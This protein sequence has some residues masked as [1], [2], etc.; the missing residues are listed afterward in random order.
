MDLFSFLAIRPIKLYG[1]RRKCAGAGNQGS[2]ARA[3]PGCTRG[4]LKW[5]WEFIDIAYCRGVYA[6]HA[7][8]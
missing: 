6:C 4:R 2:A 3:R 8:L 7:L 5:A 1:R